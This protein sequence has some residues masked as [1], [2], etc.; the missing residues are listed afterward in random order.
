MS[1]KKKPGAKKPRRRTNSGLEMS[2]DLISVEGG[3]ERSG[4]LNIDLS[5][6]TSPSRSYTADIAFVRADLDDVRLVF[7][8]FAGISTS[9]ITSVTIRY[10]K[11]NFRLLKDRSLGDFYKSL[12]DHVTSSSEGPVEDDELPEVPAEVNGAAP[13]K[14]ITE[15][16][17]FERMSFFS[18]DSEL[19][20][21]FISPGL[22]Q[23]LKANQGG[24]VP[25]DLIRPVISV[26]LGSRALYRLLND[27]RRIP[28]S[29]SGE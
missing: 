3:L 20:F 10:S 15:R 23:M 29:R 22:F 4:D 5:K 6:V 16:S 12:K 9:P 18:G 25:N 17:S 2:R 11:D 7:M 14:S 28:T 27:I 26:C 1:R 24:A 21:Y 13:E 8:Q 19:E